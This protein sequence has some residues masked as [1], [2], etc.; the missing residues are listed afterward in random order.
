MKKNSV[1]FNSRYTK[2]SLNFNKNF[3][4]K[5]KK[6][7]IIK[8]ALTRLKIKAQNKKCLVRKNSLL[9]NAGRINKKIW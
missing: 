9:F 1:G 4:N 6:I 7:F 8:T 5:G 3:S 2:D